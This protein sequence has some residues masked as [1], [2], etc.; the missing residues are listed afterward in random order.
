MLPPGGAQ[1]ETIR[2][3]DADGKTLKSW[4]FAD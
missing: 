3:E 2:F 4:R 1:I